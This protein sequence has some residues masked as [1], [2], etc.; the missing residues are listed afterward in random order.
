MPVFTSSLALYIARHFLVAF[1][2]V[3]MVIIGIILLADVIELLR[4]TVENADTG[5]TDV[6]ML[7]LLKLPNVVETVLPFAVMIGMMVCLWRLARSSELVVI[8]AAG[9]SVWQFLA[10]TLLLALAIGALNLAFLN[11]ISATLFATYQQKEDELV[12][13]E[14]QA[15]TLSEGGLWL[16]E[17]EDAE[18]RLLHARK[19]R[20]DG[21][22]LQMT[23][24]TLIAYLDEST[25][26]S[27]IEAKSGQLL[28]GFLLLRDAR[29]MAPGAATQ[30][31]DEMFL[32]TTLSLVTVKDKFAEPATISFW[33]LPKFIRFYETSGFSARPHRLHWHSLLASPLLLCAMIL[34]ASCFY[35]TTNNRLGGW[36]KRG[37]AGILAGF[38]I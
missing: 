13:S 1:G 37:V 21:N 24:V 20:Q 18:T 12:N 10:P 28:E 16:R 22:V 2:A 15:I 9:V 4:R 3:L 5:L 8:R 30:I 19:V 31:R 11:P 26:L 34:V 29:V 17:V 27:R 32:P 36:T 33:E 25:V 14:R 38:M 7:A 23:D 35:L 6:V